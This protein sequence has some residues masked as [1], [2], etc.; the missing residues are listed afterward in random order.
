MK[1]IITSIVSATVSLAFASIASA[2]GYH[3]KLK[4]H[5]LEFTALNT[6]V[7]Q[8]EKS[9]ATTIPGFDPSFY[10]QELGDW[11]M[12]KEDVGTKFTLVFELE[13]IV[14]STMRCLNYIIHAYK[15]G[16]EVEF[17]FAETAIKANE[18]G[19]YVS[20]YLLTFHDVAVGV[21]CIHGS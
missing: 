8:V 3:C 2:G 21:P 20:T 15:E 17:G 16:K 5:A 12:V 13:Q 4:I 14:D 1:N 6:F 11:E 7:L 19:H 9:G 10:D 18:E